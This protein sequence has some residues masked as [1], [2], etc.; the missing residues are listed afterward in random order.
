[1]NLKELGS[2]LKEE[3]L[4]QGLSVA[5]VMEQT[6]ISRRNI[7]AIE[8][9]DEC[10]MPHPVYAKGFVKIYS[11]TLGFDPEEFGEEFSKS[12]PIE[13]EY[14]DMEVCQAVS[15]EYDEKQI[16]SSI[17]EKKKSGFPVVLLIVIV[18]IAACGVAYYFNRDTIG[19]FISNS[20]NSTHIEENSASLN[21]AK[22]NEDISANLPDQSE[23]AEEQS[24]QV[25]SV[26]SSDEKVEAEVNS[27]SHI[28]QSS[29]STEKTETLHEDNAESQVSSAAE[30][31]VAI[32][33][34]QVVIRAKK[35]ESCWMEIIA[36]ESSARNV[37][38]K[39]G[40]SITLPYRNSLQVKFGNSNGVTIT[41]NGNDYPVESSDGRVQ[42]IIFSK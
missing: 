24:D 41:K 6:K 10:E 31:N 27:N 1:M 4:R 18:I 33:G 11:K 21:S 29:D 30:T 22:D 23:I 7:L 20:D 35:E 2:R 19:N 5:E 17:K 32:V 15:N 39:D 26:S 8:S 14:D 40:E 12:C 38:L 42:T 36:D 28:S 34:N 9:G 25:N 13:S 16:I 37:I 3:R